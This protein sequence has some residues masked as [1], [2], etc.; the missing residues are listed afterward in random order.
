MEG[1][2]STCVTQTQT[3][4]KIRYLNSVDQLPLTSESE[5]AKLREVQK[6][7]AFRVTDYYAD[8]IDWSD[9][10]DPLRRLVVPSVEELEEWGRLDASNERSITVA[11][12]TQH[13]YEDTALLLCNEICGAYCR[14]CFR[15]RLFMDDNEEAS[16]DVSEGLEYIRSRPEVTN[17][18]LTGGDPLLMSPRKLISIIE[19][20]RKIEHVHIVRIGSKMVA[21]NPWLILDQPEL[22]EGLARLSTPE[23][24]IYMMNHF[25]HPREL[26]PPVLEAL[27]MLMRA[28]VLC[29]NQCPLIQGVN[30]CPDVL[31]RLFRRLSFI[32][33]P[34]YYVF[35]GRP[36]EGNAP[37]KVSI[38][39]GFE[40]FEKA[41][42]RVSGLAARA[43]MSMSHELGKV[44]V[45][46]MDERRFYLRFH[47]AKY[48][49]DRARFMVFHRNDDAYWLDDLV[50]DGDV[51]PN[52]S[53]HLERIRRN[54]HRAWRG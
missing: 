18:L 9:P 30:D 46:G 35:Q 17:V 22:L 44:E 32:G 11:R 51:G 36:A 19:E 38:A 45:L 33:V 42:S 54:G 16:L 7:Y 28:G 4:R 50:P 40:I 14:Y 1:H 26:T 2:V 41:R 31:A 29:V 53:A 6:R 25:D 21:F 12:G 39:R 47:R 24:R 43:R 37:Y 20:V 48:E 23:K 27:D 10:H 8:L 49:E 34:P 3:P 52:V 13:K 15:K 5:R